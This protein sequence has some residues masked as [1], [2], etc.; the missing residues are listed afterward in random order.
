MRNPVIRSQAISIGELLRLGSFRPARVQRDYCWKENQQAALLQDLISAF[1]EFGLDPDAEPDPDPET[2]DVGNDIR[3]E[4]A[5]YNRD[6]EITEPYVFVGTVV[7]H[8]ADQPIDVSKSKLIG[9]MYR[10]RL[11]STVD[12]HG[13]SV[14]HTSDGEPHLR[15]RRI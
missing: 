10:Q 9:P 8:Q 2:H 5:D 6:L 13:V 1:G 12:L 14:S 7:L 3:F 4:I 15:I 11:R